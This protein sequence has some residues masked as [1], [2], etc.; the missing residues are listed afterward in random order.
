MFLRKKLQKLVEKLGF[1]KEKFNMHTEMNI[2]EYKQNE[3]DALKAAKVFDL[4]HLQG[5]AKML[6]EYKQVMIT[7]HIEQEKTR[8]EVEWDDLELHSIIK[9]QAWWQG[10]VL[11]E[12]M[13]WFKMP[14]QDKDGIKDS[15]GKGKAKWRGKKK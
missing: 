15:K 7:D 4:A 5:L 9:L 6:G 2:N 8:K 10:A 11:Q 3:L 14:K 12:E 1:W 13:G